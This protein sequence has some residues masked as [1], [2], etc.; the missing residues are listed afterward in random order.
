[1]HCDTPMLVGRPHLTVVL[2]KPCIFFARS[3]LPGM[4]DARSLR[5][6]HQCTRMSSSFARMHLLTM[7]AEASACRS[8][9][10]LAASWLVTTPGILANVQMQLGIVSLLFVSQLCFLNYSACF[11]SL[12]IFPPSCTGGVS[13]SNAIVSRLSA[14]FPKDSRKNLCVWASY[15]VFGCCAPYLTSHH[16]LS[17]YS[18]VITRSP[19]TSPIFTCLRPSQ[20]PAASSRWTSPSLPTPCRR[21]P[22]SSVVRP[23]A[24]RRTLRLARLVC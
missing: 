1:M 6:S 22:S 17:T 19:T 14:R 5:V 10:P 18:R 4:A 9:P 2:P 15:V 8:P 21:F 16:A 7:D 23:Q 20:Q 12:C 11:T 13:S 24:R 3:S